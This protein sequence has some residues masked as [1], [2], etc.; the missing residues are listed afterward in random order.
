MANRQNIDREETLYH[1]YNRGVNGQDIFL[2]SDDFWFFIMLCKEAIKKFNVD[3]YGFCQMN[4]HYHLLV[5]THEANLSKLMQYIGEKYSKYYLKK[6]QGIK[7]IGHTFQGPY[8]RKLVED[9]L[10]TAKLISYIHLNPVKANM[11]DHPGKYKWSSYLAY[12]EDKTDFDFINHQ[13]LLKYFNSFESDLNRI[14]ILRNGWEPE[15]FFYENKQEQIAFQTKSHIDKNKIMTYI[16]QSPLEAK[17][18]T[19]LQIYCLHQWAGL[20]SRELSEIFP[21]NPSS[22]RNVKYRVNQSLATE[23]SN[24]HIFINE[25]KKNFNLA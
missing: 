10:Y 6:Y 12:Q 17:E 8:G 21:L 5:K 9:I 19:R 7:K 23:N 18:K 16:D 14:D 20:S 2:E 24:T 11:V 4:N 1:V 15:L 25:I 3:F 22:I 13:E